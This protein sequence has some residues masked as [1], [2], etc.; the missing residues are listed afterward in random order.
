MVRDGSPG[1]CDALC[2]RSSR[3]AHLGC[4]L[5]HS[6]SRDV[7]HHNEAIAEL[8]TRVTEADRTGNR[9]LEEII[10]RQYRIT[11]FVVREG[12][13][14]KVQDG[15]I[16]VRVKAENA[17]EDITYKLAPDGEVRIK[18][19]PGKLAELKPGMLVEV[20]VISEA[21]GKGEAAWIS[22]DPVPPLQPPV[23]PPGEPKR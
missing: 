21:S 13:V 10:K 5:A 19:K 18:G 23:P 20:G 17:T 15:L 22:A 2:A 7:A 6:L 16:V 8:K 12:T 4:C 11:S 3:R 1:V 14:L 9:I